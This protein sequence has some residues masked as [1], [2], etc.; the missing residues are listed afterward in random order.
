MKSLS[1]LVWVI[2]CMCY[3]S[4]VNIGRYEWLVLNNCFPFLCLC[5]IILSFFLFN[6]DRICIFCFRFHCD[7]SCCITDRVVSCETSQRLPL[8]WFIL[9]SVITTTKKDSKKA[10]FGCELI[11]SRFYRQEAWHLIVDDRSWRTLCS[12]SHVMCVRHLLTKEILC[13]FLILC[14]ELFN[15]Y[16][17]GR[18]NSKKNHN[19]FVWRLHVQILFF[20]F[21]KISLKMTMKLCVTCTK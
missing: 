20:L 19:C 7:T 8:L 18:S 21:N 11:W 3:C 4:W 12:Y 2:L 9:C 6:P 15:Y 16:L 10:S 1:L 13:V 5:V 17:F 14:R